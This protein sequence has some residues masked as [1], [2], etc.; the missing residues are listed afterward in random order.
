MNQFELIKLKN[1]LVRFKNET[2][3]RSFGDVWLRGHLT[4]VMSHLIAVDGVPYSRADLDVEE[5]KNG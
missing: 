1:R 2:T 3:K 5:I 4:A